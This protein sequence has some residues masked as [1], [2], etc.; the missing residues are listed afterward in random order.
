VGGATPLTRALAA[1]AALALAMHAAAE[2]TTWKAIANCRD[3]RAQGPYQL[4]SDNGQLRVAG[5][6]NEGTRTG[7]FIFWRN[8]GVREAHVPYDDR[9]LRNGTVAT[10]YDGPADREPPR[11]VESAWRRGLRDGTTRTWYPDGRP[12]SQV[13]Y[14][15]GRIV[16]SIGWT[17]TGEPLPEAAARRLAEADEQAADAEYAQRN[18]LVADHMPS[19]G[20]TS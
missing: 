18:A 2:Q 19:C 3:G 15:Q 1:A 16:T 14:A 20:Q 13:E 4:R 17:E 8:N 11:H 5:A 10:W 7:S 9:G 6:F 12:R